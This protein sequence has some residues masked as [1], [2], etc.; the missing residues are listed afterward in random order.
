MFLT[1][2]INISQKLTET[3]RTEL[4]W[5]LELNHLWWK[6]VKQKH[7]VDSWSQNT[8]HLNLNITKHKFRFSNDLLSSVSSIN[9]RFGI[10]DVLVISEEVIVLK[11]D[12]TFLVGLDLLDKYKMV[13]NNVHNV[14]EG[15]KVSCRIPL[16]KTHGHIY[17]EWHRAQKMRT[18]YFEIRKLYKNFS[19]P[20]LDE[21]FN[22]FK[23]VRPWETDSGTNDI[24]EDI[25]CRCDACQ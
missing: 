21:L 15:L 6:W 8:N 2:Y 22:P 3:S 19:H 4:V 25:T 11:A 18:T 17:F 20:S 12:V 7:I 13:I 16:T 1:W 9:I 14:L 5:M 23:L 10:L 24:W